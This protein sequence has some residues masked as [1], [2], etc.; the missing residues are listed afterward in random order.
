MQATV[1]KA[2]ALELLDVEHAAV[3][4]LIDELSDE[5]MTRPNT[6]EYG[7]YSDQECSFKDLLA[8]LLTYEAYSIE[9]ID[10]WKRGEK[11]WI[12]DAMRNPTESR[13]VHFGGIDSRRDNS[14]TETLDEW[15]RTKSGL[16]QAIGA[17][18][19]DEWYSLAPY[20]TAEATDLGGMLEAILV[21]PPRPM[22]RHLPVHIPNSADYVR[23]LR[24]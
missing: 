1:D 23:S 21:A 13:K 8:H 9:A 14:L 12:I 11:H 16:M 4:A 3:Q 15:A 7:L 5:E 6:I 17:L 22:Y 20:E 19:D 24:R 10:S 2:R 18:T